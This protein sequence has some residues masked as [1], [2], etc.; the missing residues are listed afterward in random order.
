MHPPRSWRS[1]S[2]DRASAATAVTSVSTTYRRRPTARWR[3]PSV[4]ATSCRNCRQA[5]FDT[6]TA[7]VSGLH[8]QL[9]S[10]A[11]HGRVRKRESDAQAAGFTGAKEGSRQRGLRLIETNAVISNL[12]A[13][14]PRVRAQIQ[15]DAGDSGLL[16]GIGGV[17]Q[18]C[19]QQM[20]HSGV[21]L[22][23]SGN[24]AG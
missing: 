12:T 24:G 2:P 16:T 23:E 6:H 17:V 9:A 11:L 5:E 15:V 1:R 22:L 19:L 8:R 3:R 18:Q 7:S 10:E 13:E 20:T 21:H 14:A 4:P